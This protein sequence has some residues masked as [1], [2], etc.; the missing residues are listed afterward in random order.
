MVRINLNEN[1]ALLHCIA[2]TSY[3]QPSTLF[4]HFWYNIRQMTDTQNVQNI[5]THYLQTMQLVQIPQ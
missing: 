2:I 4:G 5:Y 3:C 1:I